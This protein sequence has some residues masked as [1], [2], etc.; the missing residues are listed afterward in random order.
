M[1]SFSRPARRWLLVV[2]IAL[3]GG[4]AAGSPA[5]RPAG[6]DLLY[7]LRIDSHEM[8]VLVAPGRPGWNLV[9]LQDAAGAA[10]TRADRLTAAVR[11]PGAAGN[12]VPVWLPSGRT[13]LLVREHGRL[14]SLDVHTS[15]APTGFDMSGPD[16]AE[17]ASAYLGRA[18]AGDH[19]LADCPAA[20]LSAVDRAALTAVMHFVVNR[21][22][23]VV[24]LVEDDSARAVAAGELIRAA[25]ARA[26]ITV[27]EPGRPAG[28]ALIVAGWTGA[29]QSMRNIVDGASTPEGVYLAPWLL[30]TEL[31]ELQV[32]SLVPLDFRPDGEPARRYLA[33]LAQRF[34]G[35]PPTWAG[36]A[37]WAARDGGDPAWKLYAPATAN[38]M[39]M[40]SPGGGGHHGARA[41]AFWL[42]GGR[43]TAVTNTLSQL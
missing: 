37:A 39:S 8:P 24:T 19:R 35:A 16:G 43:L 30:T 41:D 3:V 4:S 28:P 33:T 11:R 15:G 29:S 13:R 1:N 5:V 21:R 18:L 14:G 17:C 40:G 36:F 6:A 10:G 20:A 7:Q 23:P 42:P 34:P 32:G 12:W 22:I 9:L 31:L 2:L 27:A 38:L 26:G 25:A